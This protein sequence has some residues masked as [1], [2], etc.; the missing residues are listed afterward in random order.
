LL[1]TENSPFRIDQ[2]I[3]GIGTIPFSF[4]TSTSDTTVFVL[5]DK[6][7][8]R[9]A[10]NSGGTHTD[11]SGTYSA[12]V[13][14]LPAIQVGE[15]T[16]P[17][18][19]VTVVSHGE[20]STMGVDLISCFRVTIDPDNKLV[21]F[22][23]R[24]GFRYRR[25]GVAGIELAEKSGKYTVTS[26]DTLDAASTAIAMNDKVISIDGESV[27][28]MTPM[29]ALACLNGYEGTAAKLV[30]E[31]ANG[32]QTSV[33]L[34]RHSNYSNVVVGAVGMMVLKD[35]D[36]PVRVLEVAPGSAAFKAGVMQDDELLAIN[37]AEIGNK[38]AEQISDELLVAGDKTPHIETLKI[39]RKKDGQVVTLHVKPI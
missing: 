24:K 12:S 35:A 14:L 5:D 23:P 27:S 16:V 8:V 37:D 34:M 6:K 39:K 4:D 29:Q 26:I 36:K 20:S 28:D 10:E 15:L 18:A 7:L 33:A 32:K 1:A 30:L 11:N 2:P 3:L 9:L 38:T 25:T 13:V 19:A 17:F 31:Q 21:T 22:E